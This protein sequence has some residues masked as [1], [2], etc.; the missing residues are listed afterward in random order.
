LE[1]LAE[2]CWSRPGVQDQ[3]VTL[4]PRAQHVVEAAIA[5]VV[6][7]SR[8]HRTKSTLSSR[9]N[10]SAR[11]AGARPAE[12]ARITLGVKQCDVKLGLGAARPGLAGAAIPASLL[13][14]AL[15]SASAQVWPDQVRRARPTYRRAWPFC[16][17]QPSRKP[18]PKLRVV[19]EQRVPPRPGHDP[20]P[21]TVYGWSGKVGAKIGGNN[22]SRLAI[23]IR[24]P[25]SWVSVLRYGVSPQPLN[26]HQENSNSGWSWDTPLT[27][28]VA[29]LRAVY[30]GE[31]SG[32]A[33][34]L[35]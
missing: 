34:S 26:R 29:H 9:P 20:S 24:S 14:S 27:V 32:S 11:E 19:L 35:S 15:K 28:S 2:R 18:R 10:S 16:C 4:A 1:A 6:R 33:R 21:L 25:K 22:P 31:W 7:P 30:L 3:D 23:S 5:D 12:A 8:H 13:W 17:S